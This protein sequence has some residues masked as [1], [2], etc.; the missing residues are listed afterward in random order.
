MTEV[1]SLGLRIIPGGFAEADTALD[2]FVTKTD[3]ASDSS[4][5]LQKQS[6][7]TGDEAAAIGPKARKG[8]DGIKDLGDKSNVTTGMMH[9]LAGRLGTVAGAIAAAFSVGALANA[10]DE[11]SNL[12][13]RVGA[14]VKDMSAAPA[15]MSRLVDLANATYSPLDQTVDTFAGNVGALRDLGRSMDETA[16]YTEAMNHALTITATKGE[17]AMAVQVA[18]GK[19]M[20]IGKLQADGLETVLASGGRVAEALAKELNT[21]VSSLRKFA[22][23]GKIT[24]AVIANA[25]INSL[26]DLRREAGEMPATIGDGFTRIR[27]GLLATIGMIDQATGLSGGFANVLLTVGD[28][29]NAIGA[30]GAANKDTLISIFNGA[31]AVVTGLAAAY[32]TSLIPALWGGVAAV[33]AQTTAFLML[34]GGIMGSVVALVAFKGALLATG[35]GA[36]AVLVGLLVYKLLE[37]SEKLGGIG[38]TFGF[39]KDIGSEAFERIRSAGTGLWE[40]LKGV[41]LGIQAAFIHAF[42]GIGKAWDTVA[43]G[44]AS[45]WNMMADSSIGSTMGLGAMEKSNVGGIMGA[46]AAQRAA[47]SAASFKAASKAFEEASIPLGSLNALQT[48]LAKTTATATAETTKMNDTLA[49]TPTALEKTGK[50]AKGSKDAISDYTRVMKNLREELQLLE[51]TQGKSPLEKAIYGKQ[52]EAGVS[53]GSAG[54]QQIDEVMRLVDGYKRLEDQ[55]KKGADAVSNLFTSMLDGSKSLRAGIADLLMDLAKV[56]M[57]KAVLNLASTGLG[58]AFS[59]LGGALTANANGG[60][61]QSAGLS[62]HSGT[63]VSSPTIFPFAKGAGLMG[64][65]G[66]EAILPLKRGAD[67]KLGVSSGAAGGG[68]PEVVV[69]VVATVD[70]EGQLRFKQVGQETAAAA[71]RDYDKNVLRQRVQDINSKPRRA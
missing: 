21:N 48:E 58:K 22:S 69:T 51:A 12:Q 49:V 18:L 44:I 2:K 31:I 15:L 45:T 8:A 36:V 38:R 17:R 33:A 40:A 60:V 25:M 57:Q 53:A 59:W 43:N 4:D 27:T 37:L 63:V 30:W 5:K 13:S 54:G 62:A 11:W 68:Q 19:A 46:A 47:E 35:L 42:S 1:T 16:D 24:G 7:K 23:E 32:V 64:E 14:A 20:D 34:N 61:Y 10:A 28:R 71:V 50:A 55:T 26:Q 3:K 29:L 70:E 39:I 67:G 56:Q 66:P 41:A 65:A 52:Q 9:K 6:R